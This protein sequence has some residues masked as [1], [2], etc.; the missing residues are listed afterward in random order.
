MQS[1]IMGE[2]KKVFRPEMINRI[3]EIVVFHKLSRDEIKE[4]VDLMIARVR[5]S[6][7]EMEL[8]L[9]LSEGMKELLVDKGWDPSMGARPLRRAIQRYVEDP[10]SDKVLSESIEPGST[11]IVER[12]PEEIKGGPNDG[13]EVNVKIVKPKK[14]RAK[15]K[16]PVAVGAESETTDADAAPEELKSPADDA[17][18]PTESKE[19]AEE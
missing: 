12:L 9:E 16:A 11:V 5:T 6:M 1:G 7:K 2:L 17:D 3:D 4:I 10:V 14:P 15:K 8:Q 18:A 13:L 19:E